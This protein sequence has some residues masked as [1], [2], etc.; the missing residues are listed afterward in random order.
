MGLTY[1]I[2]RSKEALTLEQQ[3]TLIHQS[4]QEC[5]K[6]EDS[7]YYASFHLKTLGNLKI[8]HDQWPLE[9]GLYSLSEVNYVLRPEAIIKLIA[10]ET[11][12]NYCNIYTE[13]CYADN[14][15]GYRLDIDNENN[16]LNTLPSFFS[17]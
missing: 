14:S 1:H 17:R 15:F 9:D 5:I 11:L 16:T 4:F 10:D 12:Y 7:L 8:I 3:I 13:A 6:T 2:Y